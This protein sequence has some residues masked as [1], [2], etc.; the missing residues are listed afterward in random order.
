MSGSGTRAERLSCKVMN[1]AIIEGH[2]DPGGNHF[3][4]AL[5]AAY[6]EGA[7]AGGHEV[8]TI[9]VAQRQ[10]PLLRSFADWDKGAIPEALTEDQRTIDWAGHLVIV[11]PLWLGAMPAVLKGFFEQVLRP[12]F[13]FDYGPGQRWNKRLTGKSARVVVTMG[14]PGFVY[15]WY[16]GAHSVRSLERNILAFVGIKPVRSTFIG[17]VERSA[18]N[19]ERWLERLRNLGR[20]AR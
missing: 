15:R 10:F 5:A 2:P 18:P 19:R 3:G 12:G 11:Y 4:N 1:I 14:M 20:D 17:M 9:T 16:F 8:R 13:A 6:A 7:R